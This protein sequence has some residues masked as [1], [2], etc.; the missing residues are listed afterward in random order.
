M[1]AVAVCA[2]LVVTT[3]VTAPTGCGGLVTVIAVD[4]C[5]V[6]AAAVPPNDTLLPDV[7]KPMPA[8]VTPAPPATGPLVGEMPLIAA[9]TAIVTDMSNVPPVAVVA[10]ASFTPPA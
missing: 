2:S 5:A 1:V 10:W 9:G 8:I 6:I 4:D 7:P 3:T